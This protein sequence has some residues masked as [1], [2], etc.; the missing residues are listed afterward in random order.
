MAVLSMEQL[1]VSKMDRIQ[2][3]ALRVRFD[4]TRSAPINALLVVADEI[5]RHLRFRFS[6]SVIPSV[7]DKARRIARLAANSV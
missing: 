3:G 2:Y 5:S 4:G 6:Y 1:Q 7:L